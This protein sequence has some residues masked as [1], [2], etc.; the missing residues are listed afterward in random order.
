MNLEKPVTTPLLK[1]DLNWKLVRASRKFMV[2]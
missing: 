2:G 1:A